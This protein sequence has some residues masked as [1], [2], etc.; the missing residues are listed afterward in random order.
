MTLATFLHDASGSGWLAEPG[1]GNNQRCHILD[2]DL[3]PLLSV[4]IGTSSTSPI[5]PCDCAH[6]SSI[7]STDERGTMLRPL[8]TGCPSFARLAGHHGVQLSATNTH[9]AGIPS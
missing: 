4:N 1:L 5:P 8:D 3:P 9:F 7:R 6:V 2:G